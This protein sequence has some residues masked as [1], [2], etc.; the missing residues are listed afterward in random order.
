MIKVS[1]LVF[2]GR[3]ITD[4]DRARSKHPS[5]ACSASPTPAATA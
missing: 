4:V 5:A 3:A 1:D 2:A